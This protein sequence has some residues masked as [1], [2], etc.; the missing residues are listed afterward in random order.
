MGDYELD[1]LSA[2]M[3]AA[4]RH[5]QSTKADMDYAWDQRSTARDPMLRARQAKNDTRETQ[6]DSWRR[7]NDKRSQIMSRIEWLKGA[8]DRAFSEASAAHERRD[9]TARQH[10]DEGHEHVREKRNLYDELENARSAH[11][12]TVAAAKQAREDFDSANSKFLE[13]KAEHE[14]RKQAWQAAAENF[15]QA[16]SAF[17]KRLREVR[18]ARIRRNEEK[19]SLAERAGVPSMYLDDLWVS[20]DGNTVNIYFGGI[21]APNG[22]GHGHYAMHISGKVT[23]RRDPFT[24]HGSHNFT[25]QRKP[26]AGRPR[27]EEPFDP[28]EGTIFAM[29]PPQST[30]P[31]FDDIL[32]SFVDIEAT[33]ETQEDPPETSW[34]KQRLDGKFNVYFNR[35]SQDGAA[36]GHVVE[37][38]HA[39][40]SRS[41]PYV[42][43]REGNVYRDDRKD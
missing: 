5:K 26:H 22:E 16:R 33:H 41:Y 3:D 15:R 1:H 14:R 37:E 30:E 40:G 11:N 4:W 31:E 18:G 42:R 20:W 39:D 19:R 9:G 12:Q 36:H 32:G 10:A 38:R 8:A 6:E 7:F 17:M 21:G 34:E 24:P 13:A 25:D 29:N 28:F 23:Y 35:G 43:D 2:N 27:E